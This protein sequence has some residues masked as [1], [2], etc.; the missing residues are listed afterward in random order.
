MSQKYNEGYLHTIYDNSGIYLSFFLKIKS[1]KKGGGLK[2]VHVRPK[3]QNTKQERIYKL[4]PYFSVFG[5]A[6]Y[7][8]KR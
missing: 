4:S 2:G 8:F 3:N 1:K 7:G 5:Q 6:F